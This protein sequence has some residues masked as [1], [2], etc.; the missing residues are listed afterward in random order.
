MTIPFYYLLSAICYLLSVIVEVCTGSGS[1]GMAASG[2]AKVQNFLFEKSPRLFSN[3]L[4]GILHT[5]VKVTVSPV[6][7]RA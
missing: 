5:K 6:I 1:T 7:P 3:F 4:L 2:A